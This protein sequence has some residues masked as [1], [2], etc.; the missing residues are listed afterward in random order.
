MFFAVPSSSFVP[1]RQF[2]GFLKG[3]LFLFC[4]SSRAVFVRLFPPKA[5]EN[6]SIVSLLSVFPGLVPAFFFHLGRGSD[7]SPSFFFSPPS[8]WVDLRVFPQLFPSSD[9]PPHRDNPP[10]HYHPKS[11][12]YGTKADLFRGRWIS[13]FTFLSLEELGRTKQ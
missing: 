2:P 3:D 7:G 8:Y 5:R 10:I 9:P 12:I 1:F 4:L 6:S 13:A 11:F